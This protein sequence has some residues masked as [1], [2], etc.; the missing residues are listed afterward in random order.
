MT[1][2]LIVDDR[3]E[4]R[5]YLATLLGYRNYRIVEARDG[6]DGLTAARRERP[7]LIISDILMPTMDGYDFVRSLRADPDLAATPVI[8]ATA[9]YL[10]PE[11]MA[12][13]KQ[14]GV[15]TFLFKPCEPELVF[16]TVEQA[17]GTVALTKVE[18]DEERLDHQHFMVMASTLRE[19][20]DALRASKE[21][22]STLIEAGLQLDQEHDPAALFDELSA[23]ARVT[24]AA[25]YAVVGVLGLDV[26]DPLHFSVSG[27]NPWLA[28]GLSRLPSNKIGLDAFSDED[29]SVAANLA[30]HAGRIYENVTLYREVRARAD[31]LEQEVR[32][33]AAAEHAA[34]ESE[35]RFRVVL[36]TAT[37]GIVLIDA[38]GL[39]SM[40]NAAAARLFGYAAEEVVGQNVEML[41]PSPYQAEPTIVGMAREIVG[42]RKDGTTFPLEL[43]VGEAKR[44]GRTF[45]VAILHDITK[46]LETEGQLRQAQ[47]MEALGQLTGGL[48]H[49]FNNLLTVVIANLEL[50]GFTLEVGSNAKEMIDAALAASVRGAELTHQLLAFSRRQTLES[51]AI[52]INA[53]V[54]GMIRLLSRTL[55]ENVEIDL[56]LGADLWAVMADPTQLES[57][58]TNL[59]V[60]ARDAMPDGGKLIIE[61]MNATLDESYVSLNPEV[62]AGD[63]VA[64]L[65]SDT[66]TGMAP[67]V[68]A[69][70]F[71]P[72]FTTKVRGKGTG[73]GL[74]MVFGF[75]KQSG[76]HIKIYSEVGHGTTM[77]LYLPRAD[78]KSI[79]IEAAAPEE[80]FAVAKTSEIIL[81]AEDDGAVRNV[82]ARHLT[83]FGYRVLEAPN[84]PEALALLDRSPKIDLLF[85]DLVMPGGMSGVDLAEQAR[86]KRPDLKLLFTSGYSEPALMSKL[87]RIEGAVLLV[88]PFKVVDLARKVREVI[89]GAPQGTAATLTLM[90][91]K[92]G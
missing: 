5:N 2:I 13:A 44:D 26:N 56:R 3:P 52:E 8:F 73:L 88:K 69:K 70:V 71:E 22:L 78:A 38:E 57:A 91:S 7:A 89:D 66:G 47:R 54:D 12:L 18:P 11:A 17:L 31:A 64:L 75:V 15:G 49:D 92:L 4:N 59:A 80:S 68:A 61:T 24:V 60:N 65:V 28:A 33:R 90:R 19:K 74:S 62:V 36:D 35:Q 63:Y 20:A 48:A 41:M 46:R 23:A 81:L 45:F 50:L 51:S 53:L 14:C 27:V 87:A 16:S 40:F 86:A 6:L 1:T 84:G 43:S 29:E 9:H 79:A 32:E 25:K 34:R 42:R 85:T 83:R 55:G 39:V 67:E 30:A 76:G 58:L 10:R 72:F 21:R 37:D 77:R 82:V